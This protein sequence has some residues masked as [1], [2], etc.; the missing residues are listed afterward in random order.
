[1]EVDGIRERAERVAEVDVQSFAER[2][3][4]YLGVEQVARALFVSTDM[5]M[6]ESCFLW[7]RILKRRTPHGHPL[8]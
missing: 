4:G 2:Y 7:A 1:M 6:P 5:V 3:E 8:S